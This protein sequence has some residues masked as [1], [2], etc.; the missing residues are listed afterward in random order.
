MADTLVVHVKGAG[1]STAGGS[2]RWK[3]PSLQQRT[4]ASQLVAHCSSPVLMVINYDPGAERIRQYT[5]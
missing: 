4:F 3:L 5:Q 1:R 2:I